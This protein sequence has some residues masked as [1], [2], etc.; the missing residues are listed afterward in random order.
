MRPEF[1]HIHR[2]GE[3]QMPDVTDVHQA[4]ALAQSIDE[5][6]FAESSLLSA[7][8]DEIA[9]LHLSCEA[10]KEQYDDAVLQAHTL[11]VYYGDLAAMMGKNGLPNGPESSAHQ[12]ARNISVEA[13]VLSDHTASLIAALLTVHSLISQGAG[14][15]KV[16]GAHTA[17]LVIKATRVIQD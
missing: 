3:S 8:I 16:M 4:K 12:Q 11:E 17:E 13:Q 14:M 5:Q 9:T 15:S 1:V 10:A 6:I 2:I 7:A